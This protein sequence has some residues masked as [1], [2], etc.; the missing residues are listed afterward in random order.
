M[1]SA[2]AD[3]IRQMLAGE[4]DPKRLLEVAATKVNQTI[5]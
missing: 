1:E 5:R 4:T 3:M 2:F